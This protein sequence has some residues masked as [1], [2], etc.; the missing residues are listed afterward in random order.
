MRII[1]LVGICFL[2]SGC[3]LDDLKRAKTVQAEL[4]DLKRSL[5]TFQYVGEDP[6]LEFDIAE[7]EVHEATS[8]Y[9]SPNA[10]YRLNMKQHNIDLPLKNYNVNVFIQ[11]LS[12]DFTKVAEF[13]VITEVT[14]GVASTSDIKTLYGLKK[15]VNLS[16]L[17]AH[18][19]KYY[20]Y[21]NN[22][23]KPYSG[24]K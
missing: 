20:W 17:T 1:I 10:K 9:G 15:A 22:A 19:K 2:I 8:K 21:P 13:V 12:K 7:F 4:D 24:T 14:N 16:T 18:V 3:P 11:V 6:K 23:L 5:G